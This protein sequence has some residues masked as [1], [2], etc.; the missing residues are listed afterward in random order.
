MSGKLFTDFALTRAPSYR[1][2]TIVG[3]VPWTDAVLRRTFGRLVQWAASEKIPTGKWIVLSRS[4]K[5][6]EACLEI[7][8]DARGNGDVHVRTLPA[9]AVASIKFD[10]ESVSPRVIYHGL[11]DWLKW[12]RKAREISSVGFTREIYDADP[13]TNPRA[14]SNVT[15]EYAVRK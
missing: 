9:T 12:R 13:W 3:K 14:W 10:P 6:W 5:Y 2:A 15:V 11:S 1:V 7:K 4:S 8:R